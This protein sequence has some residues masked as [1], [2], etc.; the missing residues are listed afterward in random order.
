M[1]KGSNRRPTDEGKYRAEYDKIFGSKGSKE[2]SD[3]D[4]REAN[5]EEDEGAYAEDE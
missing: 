2:A 3:T 4:Q 5:S 1:G